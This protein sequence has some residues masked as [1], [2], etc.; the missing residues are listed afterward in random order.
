MDDLEFFITRYCYDPETGRLYHRLRKNAYGGKREAG[1]PAGSIGK[2]GRSQYCRVVLSVYRDGRQR[3][4]R[5]HRVVWLLMTGAWPE[6]SID[7][8]DGDSAN[9]RWTNLRLCTQ[10]QNM[11]NRPIQANNTSGYKGVSRHG[12]HW[13]AMIW[14]NR[15]VTCLGTYPTKKEAHAAR[16]EAEAKQHG[17]FARQKRFLK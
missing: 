16:L 13:R 11:M 8:I 17:E 10:S 14:A 7:H 5:A 6:G 3:L 2:T 12:S 9:N 1:S 15:K 4:Y